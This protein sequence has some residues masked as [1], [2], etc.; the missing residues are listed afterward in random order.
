M[1]KDKERYES[2]GEIIEKRHDR[3]YTTK[4]RNRKIMTKNVEWLREYK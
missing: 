2:P 4:M 3:S 1:S